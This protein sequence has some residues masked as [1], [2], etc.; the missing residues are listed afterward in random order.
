MSSL[1]LPPIT[2]SY[3]RQHHQFK[4]SQLRAEA[5]A[6]KRKAGEEKIGTYK[7]EQ[8]RR[9]QSPFGGLDPSTGTLEGAAGFR[10]R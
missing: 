10:D 1:Q 6:A 2:N 5:E 3:L 4:Q 7:A 9:K 8:E